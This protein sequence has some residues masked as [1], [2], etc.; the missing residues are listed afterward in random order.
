MPDFE[1]RAS[2]ISLAVPFLSAYLALLFTP[3]PVDLALASIAALR[4]FGRAMPMI[5]GIA[6][7]TITLAAV[8]LI[9]GQQL[10]D[11]LPT[12]LMEALAG[13]VMLTLALRVAF[14]NPLRS[15][16]RRVL[17]C[18]RSLL[19]A[20][21]LI[22]LFDP[23]IASYFLTGFAGALRPLAA[24]SVAWIVVIALGVMDFV[25]FVMLATLMS[26]PHIRHAVLNWHVAVRAL[27]AT[28]LTLLTLAKLPSI[29]HL[30]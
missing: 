6:C 2:E 13:L 7:G 23:M 26:R 1:P 5:I 17:N 27:S 24:G 4:G 21:F 9:V 3:G 18:P 8:T 15:D 16:G 10:A 12:W 22:A 14:S 25:W 28:G 30:G 19:A 11:I 29:L 20:G